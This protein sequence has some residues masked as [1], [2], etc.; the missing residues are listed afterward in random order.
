MKY[1]R[2][3]GSVSVRVRYNQESCS[4]SVIDTGIGI[5][6]EEVGLVTRRFHRVESSAGY[7]EGTGTSRV[8][9]GGFILIM[10][11]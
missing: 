3:E 2:G 7:V 6:Q 1:T 5:P 10:Y 8:L 11:V 4:L 9:P